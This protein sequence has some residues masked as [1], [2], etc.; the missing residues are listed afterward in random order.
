MKRIAKMS[1]KLVIWLAITSLC[2]V[3]CGSEEP[4]PITPEHTSLASTVGSVD[5]NEEAS[6]DQDADEQE[7][8]SPEKVIDYDVQTKLS[9]AEKRA[10]VLEKKLKDDSSLTQADMNDLAYEVYMVW[11]DT[12]NEL[13]QALKESLD[14]ET[15]DSLLEEQRA[16]ITE[17]EREV[18]Q[19]GEDAGGGSLAILVSNQRAA[20]LTKER[21]YKLAIHLGYVGISPE[22]DN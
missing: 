13:W 15:F 1:S 7:T 12:L 9:E 6:K 19:A 5:E 4:L 22:S 2:L 14:E 21:V 18:K 3:G 11:D 10:A 16:W 17:K 20:K 8:A